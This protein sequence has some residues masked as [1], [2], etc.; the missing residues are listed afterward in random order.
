LLYEA[1]IAWAR[2]QLYRIH[3]LGHIH[4]YE[5]GSFYFASDKDVG[6]VTVHVLEGCEVN[7]HDV[8]KDC[9]SID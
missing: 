2:I 1:S 3:D 7:I 5:S 4:N 6:F 8:F 9:L